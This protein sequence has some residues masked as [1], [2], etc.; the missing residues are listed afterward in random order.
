MT[1]NPNIPDAGDLLSVSQVQL[2]SNFTAA[3]ASF[4]RNHVPFSTATNN[5]K[6]TFIEMPVSAAI[7]APVPGLIAG[8]GTIYTKVDGAGRP[9]IFY[10]NGNSGNEYQLTRV[11]TTE[12]SECGTNSAYLANH[13]GGWTFLPGGV[14]DGGMLFQYGQR[15]T[16]GVSGTITFPVVFTNPPYSITV[17]A[18][19]ATG[20]TSVFILAGSEVASGFDY[21]AQAGTTAIYWTAIGV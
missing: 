14:P 6:H 17:S 16:P 4:S 7:P 9:Q 5:G 8:E 11:I 13:T 12:Y 20:T 19:R 10:T 15:T 3:N 21:V 2:K 18:T 1:Y